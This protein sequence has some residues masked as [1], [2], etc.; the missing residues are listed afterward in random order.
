[1]KSRFFLFIILALLPLA[2]SAQTDLGLW[3]GAEAQFKLSKKWQTEIEAELRTRDAVS[4]IDRWSLGASAE[5]SPVSLLGL[6][7]G[8][9][10]QDQYKDSRLTA[11]GNVV[12]DYWR[13]RNRLFG[14]VKLKFR[15]SIFK[16]DLR[17]RYQFTRKSE[18]SVAKFSS[19]GVRKDNEVREAESEN[20]FRSRVGLAVRTKSIFTPSVSY[21]FFNDLAD[22]FSLAKQRLSLGSDV[23]LT[24]RHSI[25][26]G[27]VRNF[28][29]D[30]DDDGTGNAIQLGYKIKF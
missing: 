18:V 9:S 20:I 23:R 7:V 11:K 22:G 1:M 16:L 26:F 30:S 3:T 28:Y 19:S 15:P 12:D 29:P 25:Y 5:F 2:S 4:S 17:L 24:K 8:Y 14:Q 21:E 6:G 10:F 13:I 27:Y